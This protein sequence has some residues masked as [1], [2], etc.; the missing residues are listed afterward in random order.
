MAAD[1]PTKAY[2]EKFVGLNTGRNR[3]DRAKYLYNLDVNSAEFDPK[4]RTLEGEDEYLKQLSNLEAVGEKA[5][6]EDQDNFAVE[7]VEKHHMELNSTALPT[8][9]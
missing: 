3:E 5:A 9:T 7:Q 1:L 6:L 2:K 8:L 4:S